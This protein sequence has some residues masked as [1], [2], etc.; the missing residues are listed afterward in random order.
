MAKDPAFL[1]YP[2]DYIGGTMGM[3]F[4]EKGAYI[5]LL[6]MQFNRGHMTSHMIGQTIGQLWD[7]VKVKFIQD[8]KG[9]W[10]NKRLEEEQTK[11]KMFTDSRKN[12]LS[13]KNQYTDVSGH[14]SNHMEDEN[15]DVIIDGNINNLCLMKNSKITIEDI[16]KAFEKTEDL[17][18]ADPEFYFNRA[19][20]WSTGSNKMKT[21]W[22]AVIRNFARSDLKDKKLKL[23]KDI[24]QAK[25]ANANILRE[26]ERLESKLKT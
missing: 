19:L 13:G 12:N 11:R 9:L 4:E 20:D 16:K 6:M 15:K 25:L 18:Y 23:P 17:L 7:T 26:K 24:D 21:D 10:F 8:S 14:M 3:T 22:I 5:E 2:N 1:F